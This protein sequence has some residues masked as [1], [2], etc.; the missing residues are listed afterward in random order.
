MLS[1]VTTAAPSTTPG[2]LPSPP[3]M[4]ITRML[5]DAVSEKVSGLTKVRFE[6]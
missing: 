4:T 6:A 2:M 1:K 5:I 3:R